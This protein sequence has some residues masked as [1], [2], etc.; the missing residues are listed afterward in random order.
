MKL[1]LTMNTLKA[2]SFALGFRRIRKTIIVSFTMLKRQL[3]DSTL[4]TLENDYQ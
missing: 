4:K 1:R 3:K 2:Q